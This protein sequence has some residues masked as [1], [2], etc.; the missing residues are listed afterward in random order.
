MADAFLHLPVADRREAL[1]VAADQSGRPAHLL[2]KDVWV[3]WAL[4]TLYGSALD[5]LDA[6]LRTA[7]LGANIEQCFARM[8]D[9]LPAR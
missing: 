1:S 5:D 6:D 3:V 9:P 4:A 2:E 8:G 7:F